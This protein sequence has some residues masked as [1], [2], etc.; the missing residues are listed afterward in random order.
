MIGWGLSCSRS[1]L[2]MHFTNVKLCEVSITTVGHC[3]DLTANHEQK[4]QVAKLAHSPPDTVG[5]PKRLL[6]DQGEH[7]QM[8]LWIATLA[9]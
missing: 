3:N 9:K 4:L 1:L 6:S 2:G 7:Q 8:R 5:L